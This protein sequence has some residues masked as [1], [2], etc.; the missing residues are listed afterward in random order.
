MNGGPVFNVI[1]PWRLDP[2]H[3]HQRIVFYDVFVVRR[4]DEVE[5]VDLLTHLNT[6]HPRIQFTME[7]GVD[8]STLLVWTGW[9]EE[10]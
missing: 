6:V 7:G 4:H 5:L 1:A 8:E 9:V 2:L 10:Q 3:E